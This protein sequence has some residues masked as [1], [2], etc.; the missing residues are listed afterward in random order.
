MHALACGPLGQNDVVQR[1]RSRIDV[2]FDHAVRHLGADPLH[3]L[4]G[5]MAV[6][7]LVN[8]RGRGK[9]CG[10]RGTPMRN[11]PTSAAI[12]PYLMKEN[13]SSFLDLS[14]RVPNPELHPSRGF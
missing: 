5:P 12:N 13:L 14:K 9:T 3:E 1:S 7:D 10:R 11:M 4:F 6:D 2:E 8:G